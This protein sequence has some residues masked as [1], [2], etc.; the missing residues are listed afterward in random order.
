MKAESPFTVAGVQQV[1]IGVRDAAASFTWYRRHFGFDVRIFDDTA[2]AQ[3]MRRYTGGEIQRRRA[4]LAVNMA[5]GGNFAGDYILP[6]GETNVDA[7]GRSYYALRATANVTIPVGTWTL[8]V[9]SDDGFRLR[10]PGVT[11]TNRLNENFTAAP[12][13]SPADTLVYGAGRG[14]GNT[15]GTITIT[16]TA[17][18]PKFSALTVSG[19]NLLLSGTGGVA[20]GSYYVISATDLSIPIGSWTPVLTNAFDGSGN[21]SF[22]YPMNP[23]EPQRFFMLQLP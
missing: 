12:N 8:E 3:L 19:T 4:I 5:G 6:N 11:F 15:S 14:H 16:G 10:I 7:A 13:P 20:R 18:P 23:A 22:S 9:G 21:F 1:G 2:E 17:I